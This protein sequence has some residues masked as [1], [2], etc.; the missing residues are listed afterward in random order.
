MGWLGFT[1]D[2]GVFVNPI[3]AIEIWNLNENLSSKIRTNN[4]LES[5]H[6]SFSNYL[7]NQKHP[8][9]FKLIETIKMN[10]N[11][12]KLDMSQ[13]KQGNTRWKRKCLRDKDI[14]IQN[15]IDV[16]NDTKSGILACLAFAKFSRS[17][18]HKK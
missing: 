17:V 7:V 9:P 10:E 2:V 12:V 11:L 4:Q 8:H 13:I 1:N 5:W 18:K 16:C 6:N 14:A 3:I 15:C